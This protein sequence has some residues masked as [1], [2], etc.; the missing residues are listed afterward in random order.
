MDMLKVAVFWLLRCWV[1]TVIGQLLKDNDL[2][3]A[4]L[5]LFKQWCKAWRRAWF[6][7]LKEITSDVSNNLQH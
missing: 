6:W 2:H 5:T 4:L 3:R 1:I 7:C